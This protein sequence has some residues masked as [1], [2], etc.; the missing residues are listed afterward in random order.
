MK[1]T[2]VFFMKLLVITILFSFS[3]QSS[4]FELPGWTSKPV[5]WVRHVAKWFGY[6][7]ENQNHSDKASS[8]AESM[9][10]IENT[11]LAANTNDMADQ[12]DTGLHNFKDTV[13][14]S[15]G[16]SDYGIYL[17]GPSNSSATDLYGMHGKGADPL[18][19]EVNYDPLILSP[20]EQ[21]LN[22]YYTK[23]SSLTA[24]FSYNLPFLSVLHQGLAPSVSIE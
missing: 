1:K 15:N 4:A 13:H 5:E 18:L 2:S 12:I 24:R 20:F 9:S 17:N 11:A 23:D 16:L 3:G 6:E 10:S 21:Y 22:G 14:F 7:D 8:A 19:A